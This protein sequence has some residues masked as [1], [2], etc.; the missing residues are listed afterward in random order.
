MCSVR[1]VAPG[2]RQGQAP[3]PVAG[4]GVVRLAESRRHYLQHRG[5]ADVRIAAEMAA[6]NP[7][8]RPTKATT[9]S[10]QQTPNQSSPTNGRCAL[11]PNLACDGTERENDDIK[12]TSVLRTAAAADNRQLRPPRQIQLGSLFSVLV[13]PLPNVTARHNSKL[14]AVQRY[15]GVSLLL[16]TGKHRVRPSAGPRIQ[17]PVDH[18]IATAR[19]S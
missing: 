5:W 16:P 15:S 18:E 17:R 19:S 4:A 11:A 1:A 2:N 9:H 3:S 7:A 10:M 8:I 6:R 14:Q 12:V 13:G